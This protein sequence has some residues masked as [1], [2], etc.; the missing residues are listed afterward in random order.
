M[1]T[2]TLEHYTS[3]NIHD[4]QPC[5]AKMVKLV[6]N[7]SKAKQQAVR[8]KYSDRKFM[9]VAVKA[10]KLFSSEEVTALALTS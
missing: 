4:I 10:E 3:H 1:Q 8:T 7:M 2:P 9:K 6:H 5:A